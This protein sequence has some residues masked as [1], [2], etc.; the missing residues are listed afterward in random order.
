MPYRNRDQIQAGLVTLAAIAEVKEKS[1]IRHEEFLEL[2]QQ[3]NSTRSA[4]FP[5]FG[6]QNSL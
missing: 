3:A 6:S 5:R 1:E 2:F 4:S